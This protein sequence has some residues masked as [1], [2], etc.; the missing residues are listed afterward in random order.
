MKLS[1]LASVAVAASIALATG[2]T[3][4]AQTVLFSD[5]F[6]AGL[7]AWS[8]T[9]DWHLQDEASVCDN[10]LVPF[11]SPG[12]AA[13]FNFGQATGCG[14]GWTIGDLTT[15]QPI[16]IPAGATN[17]RLLFVSYEE[18]E[19]GFGNCGWDHRYVR[20]S[21]DNGQSW[22]VVMIGATERVWYER[23]ASLDAYAGSSVLIQ[24]RFDAV[25][26]WVNDYPGWLVDDV[27]V[28]IDSPFAYYCTGKVSSAGCI[29]YVD[30][31]G[32]TS[33]TGPDNLVIAAELLHNSVS[34]KLIWS[35]GSNN[36][37]FHGGTLCVMAP[38]ARTTV[39][40]SGGSSAPAID[41][42]GH[43]SFAFTHAYLA[44]K[45][46]LAGQTL[47]VQGS[48]RDPGIAPPGNHSLSNALS[49]TVL[50]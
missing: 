39:T 6:S 9:A 17:A 49:F 38:A 12:F 43:Y 8:A 34:S 50:P 4:K 23:V 16:S 18:T 22:N 28:E 45:S 21:T 35:R 15:L 14:F 48:T 37:P 40:S 31:V 25:D 7:G 30:A 2:A 32:D 27:R 1:S 36:V 19:C 42:T 41:C 33:L 20:V 3:V 46:V 11:P 44:S 47:Y 10:D 5:D 24:F 26:P 29:P 13:A